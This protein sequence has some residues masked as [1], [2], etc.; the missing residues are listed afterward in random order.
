MGETLVTETLHDA[1]VVR[2]RSQPADTVNDLAVL[3]PQVE[4]LTRTAWHRK[5]AMTR[6]LRQLVVYMCDSV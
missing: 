6:N 1:P 4:I 2:I 5:R 3:Y